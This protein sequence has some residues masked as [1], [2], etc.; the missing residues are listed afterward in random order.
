MNKQEK[1]RPVATVNE[2]PASSATPN[3][4]INQAGQEA[5]RNTGNRGS[6]SPQEDSQNQHNKNCGCG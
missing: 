6:A 2:E 1:D 5:T 3:R 4:Q